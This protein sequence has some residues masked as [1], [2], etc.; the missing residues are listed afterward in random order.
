MV[1]VT[2]E[3]VT[4]NAFFGQYVQSGAGSGVIITED[5]YIITNNHV[6]SGASQVTVRTS[7]GTEYPA[8]VVGADSKNGY[9]RA[10]D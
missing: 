2:T 10:E 9:C 8:T 4:T 3:A 6:V 5:G 7:D 1:E